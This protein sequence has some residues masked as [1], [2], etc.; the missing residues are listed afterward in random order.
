MEAA[1]MIKVSDGYAFQSHHGSLS[2]MYIVNIT[3]EGITYKLAEHFYTA[4]FARHHDKLDIIQD[5][6]D[7]DDGYAAQRLI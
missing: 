4:E 3:Y 2:N 7:A 5:I 6:L 1:K